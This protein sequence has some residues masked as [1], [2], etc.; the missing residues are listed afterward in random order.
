MT[1]HANAQNIIS[2][3]S[4]NFMQSDVYSEKLKTASNAL[5]DDVKALIIVAE[6]GRL[7]E[8]SSKFLNDSFTNME[9]VTLFNIFSTTTEKLIKKFNDIVGSVSLDTALR[10]EKT[11][12]PLN[13]LMVM[14]LILS[15]KINGHFCLN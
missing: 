10:P 3:K 5:L 13:I 8:D 6:D 7:L 4:V 1:P 2:G 14:M 9:N 11:S 12:L 15:M